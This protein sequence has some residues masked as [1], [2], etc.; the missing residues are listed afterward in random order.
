MPVTV[1]LKDRLEA[2][3]LY[4]WYGAIKD[5]ANTVLYYNL[6]RDPNSTEINLGL[7]SEP[8]IEKLKVIK[9]S[10]YGLRMSFIRFKI[11]KLFTESSKSFRTP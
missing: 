6:T 11:G 1:P 7:F 9:T 10:F 2:P 5:P 3:V 8:D 4:I